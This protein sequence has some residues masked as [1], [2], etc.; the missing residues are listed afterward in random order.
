MEV[1]KMCLRNYWDGK[2]SLL[3]YRSFILGSLFERTAR[4][5][6]TVNLYQRGRSG[7]RRTKWK[8]ILVYS[9]NLRY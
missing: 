2:K 4:N 3:E 8:V 7:E 5:V 9:R 1:R 6:L